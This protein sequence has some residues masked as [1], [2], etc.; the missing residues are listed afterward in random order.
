VNTVASTTC[1]V[2]LSLTAARVHYGISPRV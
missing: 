1:V 2:Y